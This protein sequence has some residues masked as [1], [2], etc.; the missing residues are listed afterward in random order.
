MWCLHELVLPYLTAYRVLFSYSV[1]PSSACFTVRDTMA[2]HAKCDARHQD[3]QL[4][5]KFKMSRGRGTFRTERIRVGNLSPRT[6]KSKG[7]ALVIAG[8]R[9]G[10][11]IKVKCQERQAGSGKATGF[12]VTLEDS[13]EEWFEPKDHITKI[14]DL[15]APDSDL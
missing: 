7:K 8:P 2:S 15:D 5:L 9:R 3:C 4:L 6:P 12:T 11:L 1:D 10:T 14:E 13:G